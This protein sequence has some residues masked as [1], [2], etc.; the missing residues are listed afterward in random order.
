MH[1]SMLGARLG[2]LHIATL[3][4]IAAAVSQSDVVY[5]IAGLTT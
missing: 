4:T 1:P 3:Y 5:A 2:W